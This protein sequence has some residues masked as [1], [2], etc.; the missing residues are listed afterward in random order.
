MR[1]GPPGGYEEMQMMAMPPYPPNMGPM[2]PTM[3]GGPQG[4]Y[5]VPGPYMY[6]PGTIVAP[7]PAFIPGGAP[8]HMVMIPPG[9]GGYMAPYPYPPGGP[10]PFP[11]QM[12]PMQGP[13]RPHRGGPPMSPPQ[14][15]M[16]PPGAA[17]P[18][19]PMQFP[20]Q[21]GEPEV[22]STKQ[23]RLLTRIH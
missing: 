6:P 7:R 2:D 5:P 10:R 22:N 12:I 11:Q 18:R 21:Q 13:P 1:Y 4:Y 23:L 16:F 9:Q 19:V 3:Q 15:G 20:P 17:P 14:P 8:P